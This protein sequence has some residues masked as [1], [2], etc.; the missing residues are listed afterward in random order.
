[1]NTTT[2]THVAELC[3]HFL[4]SLFYLTWYI[5]A[6]YTCL[7]CS[8]STWETECRGCSLNSFVRIIALCT[9]F[10]F[11]FFFFFFFCSFYFPLVFFFCW[12]CLPSKG[13]DIVFRSIIEYSSLMDF[14]S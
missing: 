3:H 8:A 1:V 9:F 4:S 12:P 10:F 6:P 2:T 14:G 5:G 7:S 13:K 11:L